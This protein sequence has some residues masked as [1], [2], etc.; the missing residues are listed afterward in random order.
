LLTLKTTK[1]F[2]VRCSSITATA[3]QV[4]PS[5][6]S[7]LHNEEESGAMGIWCQNNTCSS[8]TL[9]HHKFLG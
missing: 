2:F 7:S 4:C 6:K 9:V 5:V 8:D 3:S 1:Q